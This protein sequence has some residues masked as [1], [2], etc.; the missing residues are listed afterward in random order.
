MAE[1]TVVGDSNIPGQQRGAE[2]TVSVGT[3]TATNWLTLPSICKCDRPCSECFLCVGLIN[4][5]NNPTGRYCFYPYFAD[6]IKAQRGYMD[7]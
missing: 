4:P 1:P 7:N 2:L 3:T 5:H 6:D